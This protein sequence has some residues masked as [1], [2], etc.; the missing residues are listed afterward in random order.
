MLILMTSGKRVVSSDVCL[1]VV[2]IRYCCGNDLPLIEHSLHYML[3]G[4]VTRM[5]GSGCQL[6]CRAFVVVAKREMLLS[7]RHVG[8]I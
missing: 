1:V 2:E 8:Q 3:E 6:L 7:A 5:M 4:R